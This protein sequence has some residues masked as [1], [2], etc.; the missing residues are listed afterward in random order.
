IYGQP[1]DPIDIGGALLPDYRDTDSDGDGILDIIEGH[2][3]NGDG[4]VDEDDSPYA[5]QG[6]LENL[7]DVDGDGLLDGFD[8]DS[9]V[10]DP[11][12]GGSIATSYPKN[13]P[14][15]SEMDWRSVT[16]LP[17]RWRYVEVEKKG[18]HAKLRWATALELNNEYF[19]IQ[20]SSGGKPFKSIGRVKA[21]GMSYEVTTY[22][23]MDREI[24]KLPDSRILYRIK[25]IDFD[26]KYSLSASLELRLKP[27]EKVKIE[28]SPNPSQGQISIWL[29][30]RKQEDPA[31]LSLCTLDGKE[32]IRKKLRPRQFSVRW[33]LKELPPGNY[34][35][36]W[37][38]G[39][40]VFSKKFILN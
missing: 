9:T 29:E 24:N 22:S 35:I 31:F 7:N 27:I 16:V 18:P 28:I 12:N 23:F 10:N 39:D 33:D 17:L 3:T 38:A 5:N 14:N 2:D 8:N 1:I 19:E 37:S 15:S 6:K 40:L 26:G 30:F 25:Q 32:L 4:V 34:L 13:D 21:R 36:K 11:T 20:R